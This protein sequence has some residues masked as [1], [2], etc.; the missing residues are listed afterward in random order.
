MIFTLWMPR[1]QC[2]AIV[3]DGEQCPYR[4]HSEKK[5]GLWAQT[6]YATLRREQVYTFTVF[7]DRICLSVHCIVLYSDDVADKQSIKPNKLS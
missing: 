6:V 1:Y 5:N 2:I 7:W 4:F 3:P